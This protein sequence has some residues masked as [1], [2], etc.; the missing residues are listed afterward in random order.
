VDWIPGRIP[1]LECLRARKRKAHR[2]LLLEG[3]K[4][5]DR[6]RAAAEGIPIVECTRAELDRVL[7]HSLHQGVLL[8]ADPI[9]LHNADVWT[10]S[11]FPS[12][13]VIVALDGI[14]DPHNFG[15]IVR[16]AAACG[17]VAVLFGKDRAAPISPAA[18]KS[19][20]G[21]MEY[22]DLVEAA[23]LVRSIDA[24]KEAGFWVAA[25]HADAPQPIW[26]ADLTGRVVIVIGGE[27][28]GIRRLVSQRADFHLRIPLTGP[29]TS[30]NASVSAAIAL[31]E[32]RRQRLTRRAAK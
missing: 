1:V 28:K 25:L 10:K 4:G 12:D 2:L 9:P 30:L 16:S 15:A 24:L 27:G 7:P 11:S 3:A 20:A 22:V 23:N 32:C 13:A 14:E 19:A 26:E 31:A 29:I 6:L 17:A 21:G 5:L 8:E 18:V